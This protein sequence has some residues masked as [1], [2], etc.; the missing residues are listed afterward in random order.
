MDVS[1]QPIGP[2]T[3][4]RNYN[5][6]LRNSPEERSSRGYMSFLSVFIR[7][8]QGKIHLIITLLIINNINIILHIALTKNI[9]N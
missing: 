8:A 6:S 2:E 4:A 9:N 5:Y 3:S 1:G 7:N